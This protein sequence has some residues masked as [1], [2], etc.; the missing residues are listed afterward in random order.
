MISSYKSSPANLRSL[1]DRL[2]QAAKREGVVFGRLQQHIAVLV[3]T[4]FMTALTDDQDKPLL[5]VKGGVSLELRRGIPASRTSKDLDAVS[6]ADMVTVHDQLVDAGITGWEGFTAGFTTPMPFEIP[7][8]IVNPYRFTAKLSYQ[9][10]PFSS[11]PIEVSAIEAG[12]TDHY[13]SVTSEALALIGLPISDAVPCMTLPWQVAQKIHA[14]TEPVEQ[15]RTND[16][17]HDLVD[18]QLLEALLVTE[19]LTETRTASIAVF[20][21]RS[22]HIWR[23]TVV[24]QPHW[25]PIYTRALEGL[26]DLG[27]APT[28]EEAVKR[29]QAF[30][31]QIDAS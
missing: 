27:L 19:Q 3:I 31:N 11:V 14:C 12:N 10:R 16:R 17:A 23:P 18:L 25:G 4:Q 22:K 9:G 1:R 8:Q 29:I 21:A 15:P 28:V 13:D 2:T 20:E 26:E 7:G 5:L 6:R 24:A 30:V